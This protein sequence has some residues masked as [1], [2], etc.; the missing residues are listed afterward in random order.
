MTVALTLVFA[1][2]ATS[3]EQLFRQFEAA[4]SKN[5]T[6]E[7]R[8]RR[9]VIFTENLA[10]IAEMNLR[11]PSAKYGHLSPLADWSVKEFEARNTLKP[12]PAVLGA[13]VH[14]A[15]DASNLTKAFDW[16]E[17]GAV[18]PVKNQKD[19]GSCWAFGTVAGIEGANFLATGKLL[20]LSEQEL[21][22]CDKTDSGC[23]GGL[24]SNALN[25]VK[26]HGLGEESEA[27]YPYTGETGP[28]CKAKRSSEQIFVKD[29]Q[30]VNGTN[31]DQLAAAL[32]KLGPL[33]IGINANPLQFYTSGVA[34]PSNCDPGA[35][36]HAVVIVGFGEDAG[37]KYWTIRNS[38]GANWGEQGYFRMVR[39][40]GKCG[41]NTNIVAVT[42][43][44]QPAEEII[45]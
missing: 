26:T 35:L 30:V 42:K 37:K 39:G 17:K 13:A 4:H 20:S 7:E 28:S 40:T 3:P 21:V 29:W 45:V 8:A 18:N 22:D 11:D 15:L 41:L 9:L 33:A 14:P 12:A 25:Y 24:P 43:F 27:A 10:K 38:W 44:G 5:Y 32:V 6:L 2:V 19:C 1:A 23:G 31:E 34:D 36:D 16:R